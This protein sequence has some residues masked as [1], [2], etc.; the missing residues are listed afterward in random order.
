MRGAFQRL[1]IFLVFV[2]RSVLRSVLSDGLS[3]GDETRYACEYQ[4]P[5]SSAFQACMEVMVLSLLHRN[6]AKHCDV[7][8][9]RDIVRRKHTFDTQL[10]RGDRLRRSYSGD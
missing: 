10:L 2:F 8:R 5:R 4:C 1:A 6:L 9:F 3:E 7:A